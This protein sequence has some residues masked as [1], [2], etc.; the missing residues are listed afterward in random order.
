MNEEMAKQCLLSNYNS[1]NDFIHAVT[2]ASMPQYIKKMGP[3]RAPD[4]VLINSLANMKSSQILLLPDLGIFTSDGFFNDMLQ[5]ISITN[6]GLASYIKDRFGNHSWNALTKLYRPTT[7]HVVQAVAIEGN[8]ESKLGKIIL[9]ATPKFRNSRNRYDYV[10][11][12]LEG[13]VTQP[14]LLL[15]LLKLH[16]H[17]KSKTQFFALVRY[18]EEVP[19]NKRPHSRYQC[20]WSIYQYEVTGRRHFVEQVVDVRTIMGLASMTPVPTINN[21]HPSPTHPLLTDTFW[22][23]HPTYFDRAGWD[24]VHTENIHHGAPADPKDDVELFIPD[25]DENH[26]YLDVDDNSE[27]DEEEDQEDDGEEEEE[28]DI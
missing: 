24:T 20:P 6:A 21:P 16:N 9:Y 13:G 2:T 22:Y 26:N 10:N 12:S 27:D 18:L 15:M 4:T 17:N 14:A 7:L 3:Y 19:L 8:K 28:E 1:I 5:N 23:M 11:I 25:V